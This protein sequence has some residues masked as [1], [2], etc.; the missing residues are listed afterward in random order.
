MCR[1]AS[2]RLHA[3]WHGTTN[4]HLALIKIVEP[5]LYRSIAIRLDANTI[6]ECWVLR[7]CREGNLLPQD[8]A[9]YAS[10]V[11]PQ[12]PRI[13]IAFEWKNVVVPL[14]LA[15]QNHP[16]TQ[17]GLPVGVLNQKT[18]SPWR[19]LAVPGRSPPLPVVAAGYRHHAAKATKHKRR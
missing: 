3:L 4:S 12:T 9:D 18:P 14:R 13:R 5:E 15:M 8:Q 17:Y 6:V 16:S 10:S 19:N 11:G 7:V 1:K 2:P